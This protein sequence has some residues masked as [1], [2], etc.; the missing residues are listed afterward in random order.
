MCTNMINFSV[1]NIKLYVFKPCNQKRSISANFHVM[2]RKQHQGSTLL[3]ID[4]LIWT[5]NWRVPREC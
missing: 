2:I 3:Q 1:I 5:P 4:D